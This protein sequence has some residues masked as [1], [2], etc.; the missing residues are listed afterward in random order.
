M[1]WIC[2]FVA[3]IKNV[4]IGSKSANFAEALQ[5][6]KSST[7]PDFLHLLYCSQKNIRRLLV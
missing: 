4:L 2:L 5:F 3:M 6:F 1:I 7:L